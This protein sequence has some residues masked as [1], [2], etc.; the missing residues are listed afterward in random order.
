MIRHFVQTKKLKMRMKE[1]CLHWLTWNVC[2]LYLYYYFGIGI[3]SIHCILCRIIVHTYTIYMYASYL[4]SKYTL[5]QYIIEWECTP[6]HYII[7]SKCTYIHYMIWYEVY[8]YILYYMIWFDI[9]IW[10]VPHVFWLSD[11]GSRSRDL[12]CQIIIFT[13]HT[14]TFRK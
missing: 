7:G 4:G 3:T 1:S 13:L 12:Y 10:R 11:R 9:L 14:L 5:A 8:A 2:I 6:T